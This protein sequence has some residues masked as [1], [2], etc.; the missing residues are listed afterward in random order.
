MGLLMRKLTLILLCALACAG[1]GNLRIE[2]SLH[3]QPGDWPAFARGIDHAAT[4][5]NPVTPPLTRAWNQ[6]VSAGVGNG[7]PVIVDSVVFVGTLR[8]DLY[9]MGAGDGKIIGWTGLGD[10]IQGSPTV[11]GNVA[12]VALSSSKESLTAFDLNDGKARWKRNYGDVETSPLLYQEHLF[13]GNTAGTFYC[14]ERATGDQR[15]KYELPA[16]TRM[17]GI[18]SSPAAEAGT[19]V[20]GADDG[21]LTALNAETGAL[22]WRVDTGS[23]LTAAPLVRDGIIYIGNR[24]GSVVAVERETGAVLW[25]CA[26][27]APVVANAVPAGDLVVVGTLAGKAFG[28]RTKDGS[29]AWVTDLGGPVSAGGAVAGTTVYVGTLKK[30]IF[31]LNAPDGTVVWR[32]SLDGR[33]RTSPAL[34]G[35]K[36]FIATDEHTLTA[37]KE[38]PR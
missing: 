20:F 33:I 25:R 32:D 24:Q 19:V 30:Q 38:T 37:F 28:I 8:G 14:L 11:D 6:D 15:W 17:K 1:C 27:G 36:L 23:P 31:A 21:W 18:R 2:R 9:A 13:V 34:A 29:T 16:N 4:A 22:R 3:E 7:S 35:G 26:T 12:F 5:G 10:A